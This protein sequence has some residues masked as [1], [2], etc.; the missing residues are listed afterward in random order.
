MVGLRRL[1]VDFLS[2]YRDLDE[3]FPNLQLLML[4]SV[5]INDS[6]AMKGLCGLNSGKIELYENNE[7]SSIIYSWDHVVP[8]F[9]PGAITNYKPPKE[10]N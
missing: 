4:H 5:S 2:G 3:L 6:Y 7:I 10:E 9:V 1:S 8:Y